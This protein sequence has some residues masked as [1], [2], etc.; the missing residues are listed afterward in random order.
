MAVAVLLPALAACEKDNAYVPPPPPQ[1][2]VAHPVQKSITRYFNLTGNTQAFQTVDLEARVQGFLQA[3][4]YVDGTRAKKGAPL[5]TIQQDTYQAQLEQAKAA[6]A[7]QEATLANAKSEYYRQSTLGQESFASQAHVED[8]KTRVDKSNADVLSARANLQIAQIN[9]G[10]TNVAAPFDGIVTNHLVDVGAL[11]GVTGPTKLASITQIDPLY[12][13][14][15]VSETQ[16]LLVKRALASRGL[17]LTDMH[18]VPVEVGLQAEQGYPHAGVLDYVS[19]RVDPQTGTLLLRGILDNKAL[20]LLPGLF[21]RVRV[22]VGHDKAAVLVP[23]DTIGTNQEG[24]YV[25]V[26]GPNNEVGQRVVKLGELDGRL[27]VIESGLDPNDWVV[28]DGLQRAV[29]GS[30]VNPQQPGSESSDTTKS[31]SAK[32]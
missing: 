5:F 17:K 28:T 27:R 11:V 14:F 18:A 9:L 12:V 19:P 30:K 31:N 20:A 8:A 10:Y 21:V 16:V 2:R 13:Y 22:P 15:S 23:D 4:S 3:I 29:P 24:S 32:N 6:L 26:V 7:S 25:L 1:V